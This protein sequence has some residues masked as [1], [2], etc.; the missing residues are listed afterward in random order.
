MSRSSLLVA[1]WLLLLS[2]AVLP[3]H[4]AHA[5]AS[6]VYMNQTCVQGKANV[7]FSWVGSDT[8]SLQQWIDLS[9][10]DNGWQDGTF[11]SAGPIAGSA[12]SYTW[13]GLA[14]GTPHLARINQ[15][16]ASGAWDPSATFSFTTID[17]APP[18]P[19]VRIPS[20]DKPTLIGFSDRIAIGLASMTPDGGSLKNCSP[21]R[22]YAYVD[23]P[24][25]DYLAY[26]TPRW[27][28][29]GSPI[30]SSAGGLGSTVLA[31]SFSK[32]LT[33]GFSVPTTNNN[34]TTGPGVYGFRVT[35]DQPAAPPVEG[36]FT[37][38]C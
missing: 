34:G 31:G 6:Q 37:V 23:M 24:S 3:L 17:C 26:S 16:L 27:T 7:T 36:S 19:G 30:S 5:S 22:I 35:F 21:I 12:T 11:I 25:I 10:Q 15:Q 28:F 29:N 8:S 1:L 13:S 32:G 9:T 14:A 20:V 18:P 38:T 4:R 2:L 33:V